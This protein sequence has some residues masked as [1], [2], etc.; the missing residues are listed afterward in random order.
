MSLAQAR[1]ARTT[2]RC[3]RRHRAIKLPEYHNTEG[4]PLSRCPLQHTANKGVWL[5]LSQRSAAVPPQ[6]ASQWRTSTRSS[7]RPGGPSGCCLG[8]MWLGGELWCA[9][10][11]LHCDAVI[12]V[13]PQATTRQKYNGYKAYGNRPRVGKRKAWPRNMAECEAHDII[14]GREEKS[15]LKEDSLSRQG[16]IYFRRDRTTRYQ[17]TRFTR[18]G[19]ARYPAHNLNLDNTPL[20]GSAQEIVRSAHP[21]TASRREGSPNRCAGAETTGRATSPPAP[22]PNPE[23]AKPLPEGSLSSRRV[24]ARPAARDRSGR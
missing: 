9:V 7:C 24:K 4:K 23:I 16:G 3:A 19:A 18:R 21:S 12:C 1:I 13:L 6:T 20:N 11:H 10:R 8:E 15:R 14:C 17:S 22:Y 2:T 5:V